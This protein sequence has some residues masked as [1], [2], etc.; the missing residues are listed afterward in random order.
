MSHL[1]PIQPLNWS[2]CLIYAPELEPMSAS[3]LSC[4]FTPAQEDP[5]AV[6]IK[7]LRH[8]WQCHPESVTV[9]HVTLTDVL[10]QISSHRQQAE[11]LMVLAAGL[12]WREKMMDL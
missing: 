10:A 12:K 2:R 3:Q 1:G 5:A 8:V 7:S 6:G 4:A 9:C 11:L